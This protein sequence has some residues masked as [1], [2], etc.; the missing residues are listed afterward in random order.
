MTLAP[1]LWR[2][3]ER[4]AQDRTRYTKTCRINL[5]IGFSKYVNQ[6]EYQKQAKCQYILWVLRIG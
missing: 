5:H 1:G 4:V 2:L 6:T 3:R